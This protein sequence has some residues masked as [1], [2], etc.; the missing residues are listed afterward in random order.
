MGDISGTVW[1]LAG[2]A[3]GGLRAYLTALARGLAATG[4][5]VVLWTSAP[6]DWFQ[7]RAAGT[8]VRPLPGPL[9]PAAGVTAPWRWLRG[10]GAL[11]VAA[12]QEA[13]LLVHAHGLRASA[14]AVSALGGRVPVVSTLHTEP[15][16]WLACRL[17]GWVARRS[18]AL[19]LVSDALARWAQARG[20]SAGGPGAATRVLPPPLTRYPAPPL[21]AQAARRVLGLPHL[22]PVVGTVARLSPE[23]GVDVLLRAVALLRRHDDQ[24]LTCAVIGD[25]PQ[26]DALERLARQLGIAGCVR[27]VGERPDA[28][29]LVRAIDV[30]VQPSRREAL[31]LAT[32]EAMAAARPVVVSRTGGLEDLVRDGLDG[33]QVPPGDPVSLARVLA[34]LLL[35]RR[36]RERLARAAVARA[37][38]WPDARALVQG[39][40]RLYREVAGEARALP[41]AGRGRGSRSR[42]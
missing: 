36:Q 38:R 22:G 13:P 34:E 18:D 8:G 17:A 9:V 7:L 32:L 25:G 19:V 14:L 16:G 1:L 24:P 29:R 40:L 5:N 21:P 3:R 31:G 11:R 41:G 15:A 27:W 20:L 6:G 12:S 28:A 2:A 39:H 30:Y 33:R 37:R 10:A 26:R 23:K 4:M 35:D 42:A